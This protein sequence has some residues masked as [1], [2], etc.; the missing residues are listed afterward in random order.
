MR[1]S[2]FARRA[3]LHKTILGNETLLPC[4]VPN[5]LAALFATLLFSV[6]LAVA[7]AIVDAQSLGQ[8]V[9]LSG[10]IVNGTEGSDVPSELT[11]FALVIDEDAETI[12]ERVEAVTE[13]DGEFAIEVIAVAEGRFYRVVADDGVYTPFVDVLPNDAAEE[14]TLTVYDRTTALDD[15]SVTTYSM[16]IPAIDESN[17][18]IGVLSAVNLVNSGDKVYLPD[19]ADPALTGFK[20]L[21]FNLP[22][23]YQQLTV[24][25]DLPSG[26]VM[27][28]D[29]GFAISNP[30]PPGKYSMVISYSAPFEDGEFNYP[31]RLPFGAE[32]VTILV[33]EGSGEVSGLGLVKSETAT[34][35]DDRYIR[36]E[37]TSY[38]RQSEVGV[39]I[40]GLPKPDLQIEFVDF[41][42][43]S[44]ARLAIVASVAI[45]MFGIL[46]YV[47]AASR[48]HR[49]RIASV[50]SESTSISDG[51]RTEFLK[52]IAELDEMH[53]LGNIDDSDYVARRRE[54]VQRAM[55]A[56]SKPSRQ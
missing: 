3:L 27:E 52:A 2:G 36:Y 56:D 4:R 14:I 48:R 6:Y 25:S 43:S 19:L 11:V 23:G 50:D 5:R 16:V 49:A 53:D 28:I 37:G 30:V 13:P 18:I 24:E 10:K 47:V 7:T 38:D 55:D 22:V 45:A 8:T 33:P 12:V 42:G 44:E 35:G 17:E 20:L 54:L 51:S 29:T 41:L 26:N 34:I 21:R 1:F 15:I 32:S 46:V 31:L 39:R 40:T 9:T